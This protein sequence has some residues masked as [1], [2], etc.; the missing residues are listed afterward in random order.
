[1]VERMDQENE[2]SGTIASDLPRGVALLADLA[3]NLNN[4]RATF[5][6]LAERIKA[7][8]L[9]TAK[10]LSLL[11]LKN[12]SFLSYMGNLTYLTLRK[13]KGAKIED[14]PSVDRLVETRTVLERIRP[15]EDKLKYQIDKHVKVAADGVVTGDDPS[16][17]KGNIDNIGSSSDED[18][19]DGNVKKVKKT[20]EDNQKI[21]KVPKISQTHY[22][23]EVNKDE[24]KEKARRRVLNSTML[25]DAL[26]EHTED[27]EVV[28]NNDVLKQKAMK[29]RRELEVFEEENMIRK[30][31]SRRDQAAMR[32][33]TTLGTMG[34]EILGFN[35]MDALHQSYDP[36]APAAKRQKTGKSSK[37]K[38]KGKFK[39]K[40]G[41][42]KKRKH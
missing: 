33:V 5:D 9:N 4:V 40:K 32:Q 17:L 23:G 29:K 2:I 34:S 27:P 7:G 22:D 26:S 14:D 30:T 11:E 8:E 3:T 41:F 25:R 10:G 21:Y 6:A 18:E 13:L 12:Q 28:F 1:M 15:L 35:N 39:G 37:N 24:A 38:G 16:R 20:E 36:T 31:V 42:K 19:E